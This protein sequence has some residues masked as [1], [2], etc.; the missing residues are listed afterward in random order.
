[1]KIV[2]PARRRM[3][4]IKEM[5]YFGALYDV[6]RMINASLEPSRVL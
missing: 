1:V 3:M 2:L 4:K 5:D 6:A